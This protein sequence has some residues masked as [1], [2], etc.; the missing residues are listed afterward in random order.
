MFSIDRDRMRLI[1]YIKA[2]MAVRPDIRFWAS[3][4]T[5]PPWMKSNNAYDRGNIKNDP[6]TL[7][8]LALYLTRFVEEYEKEGI[9]VDTIHPQNEP[10]YQQDYPSCGWTG[11]QMADFI[12]TYL[13]PT[14]D[15]HGLTTK[16][17]CGTMSN[18]TVD[19]DILNAVVADA[20][21]KAV[22][23]GFG[24]QWG[25]RQAYGQANLD[26]SL[27]I[28]QTEH[29]CGN[30]PNGSNSNRAPNDFAYGV[31]S[32]GYIRD[33]IKL[34]VNHYSA[35]NMVLDTVG[36]SLDTVRP[37]AQNAP[38]VVDVAAQELIVSPAYYVMRHVS[39]YADPGGNVVGTSSND[40]IAFKNPDGTIVA[41]IYANA[42]RTITVSIAGKRLQFQMPGQGW[43]TLNVAPN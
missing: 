37:W 12:K 40:A 36:R 39:Q 27:E 26:E 34:G 43:A 15:D 13:K 5:P 3:P 29:Q 38:L 25:M 30:F 2:A 14:F 1:P 4:W 31:E 28:W 24:L 17:F 6:T 21:A 23:S 8:A 19:R 9:L 20:G 33:W 42:A 41:V 35:W 7:Q 11:S 22:I 32:W 16:I 10:G 18:P